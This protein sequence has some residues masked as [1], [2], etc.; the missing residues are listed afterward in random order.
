MKKA[1]QL[2][3]LLIVNNNFLSI[4]IPRVKLKSVVN[5]VINLNFDGEVEPSALMYEVKTKKSS[6]A[7]HGL[8]NSG[9]ESL[10]KMK[11]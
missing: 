7:K 4:G 11:S 8:G 2:A 10:A 1:Y 5:Y 6:D 3:L 9:L